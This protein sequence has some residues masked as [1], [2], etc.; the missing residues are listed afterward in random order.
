ME[1][2]EKLRTELLASHSK[3]VQGLK[4]ANGKSITI[5]GIYF[6]I[7]DSTLLARINYGDIEL[8]VYEYMGYKKIAVTGDISDAIK[9]LY[10]PMMQWKKIRTALI[11]KIN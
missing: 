7:S 1:E 8:E 10:K 2:L 9:A 6:F 3:I 11:N 4:L 5:E